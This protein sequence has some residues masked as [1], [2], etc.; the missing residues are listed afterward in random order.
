MF[1]ARLESWQSRYLSIEARGFNSFGVEL[2]P[3][4]RF[5]W[6]RSTDKK[7]MH[8]VNWKMVT[9]SASMGR[10]RIMDLGDMNKVLTMIWLYWYAN[11]TE[12]LWREV[13]CVCTNGNLNSLISSLRNR[14]NNSA[15]LVS[16]EW[17]IGR[18]G[19]ASDVIDQQ[20]RTLIGDG[21]DTNL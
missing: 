3:H 11:N 13:V 6:G 2:Y 21:W 1:R 17:A 15:L 20:F 16:V 14:D 19:S 5:L 10:L 9:T 7:M 8:F 4:S 12:A 18:T